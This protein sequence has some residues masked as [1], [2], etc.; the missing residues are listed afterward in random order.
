M[1]LWRLRDASPSW[2]WAGP[3]TWVVYSPSLSWLGSV[4]PHIARIPVRVQLREGRS[5]HCQLGELEGLVS[6]YLR[7]SYDY[8]AIDWP[9]VQTIIDAGANAGAV[10]LWFLTRARQASIVSV[11]PDPDVAGRLL[12]NIERNGAQDRVSTVAAALGPSEGTA[13]FVAGQFTTQGRIGELDEPGFLVPVVTLQSIVDSKQW[14]GVDLLK[15]DCEGSEYD[16][17]FNADPSLLARITYI[18]GEYH[19]HSRYIWPDLRKHLQ[20][21]GYEV[22]DTPW[23]RREKPGDESLGDFFAVRSVATS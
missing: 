9:N 15:L 7:R 13:R 21:A 5:L 22:R 1:Q 17:L 2:W 20:K 3:L 23:L 6:A 19:P 12:R 16:I 8:P 14:I 18:V 11:E 10:T 4:R